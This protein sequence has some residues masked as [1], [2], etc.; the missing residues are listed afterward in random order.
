MVL[1][2]CNPE[3]DYLHRRIR[4]MIDS[5]DKEKPQRPP[6]PERPPQGQPP[7]K[8]AEG[9]EGEGQPPGVPVGPGRGNP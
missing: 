7:I 3:L 4:Q 9:E 8:P 1:S 6:Q 5:K 2:E